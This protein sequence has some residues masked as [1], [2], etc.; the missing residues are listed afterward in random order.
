MID[1]VSHRMLNDSNYKEILIKFIV[2]LYI[3]LR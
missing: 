3:V 2:L 1:L